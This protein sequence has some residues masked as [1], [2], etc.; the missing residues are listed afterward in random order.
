[1]KTFNLLSV[2]L[3]SIITICSSFLIENLFLS[4]FF[5]PTGEI[6]S[7]NELLRKLINNLPPLFFV[8]VIISNGLVSYL[9]G[10]VPLLIGDGHL[11]HSILIGCFAAL[12]GIA[13]VLIIPFPV[14]YKITSAFIYIPGAYFGGLITKKA[15]ITI[16]SLRNVYEK[17]E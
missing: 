16:I 14:W 13:H 5:T 17:T 10:T 4:I 12:F 1:M 6:L 3:G 15:F 2:I 11:K 8:A 7:N 9:G